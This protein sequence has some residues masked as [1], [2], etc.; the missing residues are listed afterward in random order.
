MT[1]ARLTLINTRTIR[2]LALVADTLDGRRNQD[3]TD[4]C[5]DHCETGQS[6]ACLTS[7][8]A[9]DEAGRVLGI[10]AI[11]LRATGRFAWSW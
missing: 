5:L 2:G 9:A 11:N 4:T 3:R 8:S 1:L 10:P 6:S 7:Y